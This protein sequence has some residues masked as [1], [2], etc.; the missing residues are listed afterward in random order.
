MNI[1]TN[2]DLSKYSTMRVGGKGA[3][4][5]EVFGLEELKEAVSF[6]KKTDLEIRV[7]GEGS[8]LF[9]ADDF[10]GLVIKM[11]IKG[12]EILKSDE[13]NV[14]IKV[15]AGENWHE[16][17]EYAVDQ[18]WAG[19]ENMALIPGTVG[20]APVQ[21][22]AAYGQNM[23]D[24]F[25][26]LEALNI[27]TGEIEK[28]DKA[29][30]EFDYRES[31]FKR[32]GAGKYVVVSVTFRLNKDFNLEASYHERKARFGSLE[33]V[34]K[35]LATEPYSAKDVFN[36]VI[37]IRNQKLPSIKEYGTCGSFFKNPVVSKEKF[38]ELSAKVSELQS[39]PVE[40]L[41]YDKK[42]WSGV[43]DDYVKIPAGRLLDELGWRDKWINHVA[44]YKNHALCVVTDGHATAKDVVNYVND[45]KKSVMDA[46]GVELEE[47]VN[48]L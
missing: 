47:E 28:F 3:Y 7:I 17:V 15:A 29:R 16:F 25:E 37:H 5:S 31:F 11:M 41:K 22:I 36:A 32:E 27:E 2:V 39:Y 48:I 10:K 35:Q 45:M 20:A 43:E 33:D 30:C 42:D 9:F 21:N 14:F 23:E 1:Q 24:V 6:A 4:L 34:L 46:Y 13:E 19:I 8:N 18:N 12:K 44:S 26:E 38:K 40:K